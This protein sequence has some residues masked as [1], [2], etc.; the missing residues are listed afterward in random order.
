MSLNLIQSSEK[1]S[2][3][4]RPEARLIV[5]C[6]RTVVDAQTSLEIRQI[7]SGPIDWTHLLKIADRNCVGPLLCFNLMNNFVDEVPAEAQELLQNRFKEYA[8]R[9]LYLTGEL[10][11]VIRLFD[12]NGIKALPFKG[13]TLAASAYGNIAL[14]YFGDLDI[15]IPKKDLQ[16]GIELLATLGYTDANPTPS[17]A[18]PHRLG[19]K[20]DLALHRSDGVRIELH[21]RLS[22]MHFDLPLD[23]KEVWAHLDKVKIAG[24]DL[25]ILPKEELLLYLCVHGSRHG[26]ERLIW[27]SDIA[28]LVRCGGIDWDVVWHQAAF[29][30]C[31]RVLSLSLSLANNLLGADIPSRIKSASARTSEAEQLTADVVGRLFSDSQESMSI[32][33]WYSYHLKM[34]ERVRDRIKIHY[35]YYMRYFRLALRPNERDRKLLLLP[36]SLGGVYYLLRP[37]R[38]INDHAIAPLMRL[39]RKAG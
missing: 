8:T 14:R 21:W 10:I 5:C 6:A 32:S 3:M 13:P 11:K 30:G 2:G 38:L 28:E 12:D 37:L 29:L 31:E 25:T 18:K 17:E 15:L 26:W 19:S 27:I 33:Q 24:N 1:K 16:K 4:N 36:S 23:L 39:I 35:H 20:K 34:K 22:G 7:L 9:N